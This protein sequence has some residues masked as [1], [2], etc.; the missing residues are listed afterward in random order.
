MY[1]LGFDARQNNDEDA[2]GMNVE[3]AYEYGTQVPA[4]PSSVANVFDA[5]VN[6]GQLDVRVDV[7]TQSA[8]AERSER[9]VEEA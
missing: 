9:N 6:V 2:S 7:D 5:Y 4:V 3:D 8:V 1:P